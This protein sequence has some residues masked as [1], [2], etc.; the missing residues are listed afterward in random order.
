MCVGS[1]AVGS[2]ALGL[3]RLSGVGCRESEAREKS[4]IGAEKWAVVGCFQR[5]QAVDFY[6]WGPRSTRKSTFTNRERRKR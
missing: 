4:E 1:R 5:C 3:V 2:Q 6:M